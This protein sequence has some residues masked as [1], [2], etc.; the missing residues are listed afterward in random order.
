MSGTT[1][2]STL[3]IRIT[4]LEVQ[5]DQLE[6]LAEKY[7]DSHNLAMTREQLHELRQELSAEKER[8]LTIDNQWILKKEHEMQL[9][10]KKAESVDP[11]DKVRIMDE[12]EEYRKRIDQRKQ[13][14]ADYE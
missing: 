11:G 2:R 10:L 6:V 8:L 7:T 14:M 3:V 9:L 1:N 13:S 5:I 4:D 12:V